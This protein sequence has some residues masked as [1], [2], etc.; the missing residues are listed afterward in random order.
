MTSVITL[1]PSHILKR[2]HILLFYLFI[3][4]I[5]FLP[6]QYGASGKKGLLCQEKHKPKVP[7]LSF[8][9]YFQKGFHRRAGAEAFY[10]VNEWMRMGR[11][12]E[13]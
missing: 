11:Q 12:A 3:L 7:G 6:R 4:Q 2:I 9:V 8:P 13:H 10:V 5:H 1:C